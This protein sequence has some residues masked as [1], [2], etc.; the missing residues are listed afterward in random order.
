M[1]DQEKEKV[2]Q[3]A[4]TFLR[5]PLTNK[6]TYAESLEQLRSL[7]DYKDASAL[8]QKYSAEFEEKNVRDKELDERRKKVR[9]IQLLVCLGGL[10]LA[11]LLILLV[12]YGLRNPPW[13]SNE[14]AGAWIDSIRGFTL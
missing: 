13:V 11:V 12:V 1:T 14:T 2:Y 8:Y 9:M 10:V 6:D 7:E 5:S 4:L 3:E